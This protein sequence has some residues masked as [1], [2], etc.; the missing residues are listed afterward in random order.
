VSVVKVKGDG[1]SGGFPA[2]PAQGKGGDSH[3]GVG[4]VSGS[5]GTSLE[6]AVEEV[7]I[8]VLM[9]RLDATAAKLSVFPA[10][11][12]LVEYRDIIKSLLARALKGFRTQRDLRWRKTDRSTFVIV[13]KT[14]A[15]LTELEAV[16]KREGGR[17]E[18]LRL[19]GEIKGCLISLLL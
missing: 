18:A 3:R 16:F 8:D 15:T 14:E 7:E 5:F 13:E 9:E 6:Q 1:K 4:G 2:A 10:E 12:L 11:R 19:M 17:A